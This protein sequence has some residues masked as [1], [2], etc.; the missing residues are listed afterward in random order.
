MVRAGRMGAR[1]RG[2]EERRHTGLL[3]HLDGEDLT[4]SLFLGPFVSGA[5]PYVLVSA[6]NV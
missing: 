3:L 5:A 6:S 2:D 1:S 4:L